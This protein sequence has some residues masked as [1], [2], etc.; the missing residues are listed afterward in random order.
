M[1]VNYK[2]FKYLSKYELVGFVTK[3]FALM[4]F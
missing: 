4:C 1:L 3:L 2:T